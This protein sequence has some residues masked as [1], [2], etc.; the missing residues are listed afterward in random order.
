MRILQTC[1]PVVPQ[2]YSPSIT[3]S[4]LN[5]SFQQSFFSTAIS[6]NPNV[7]GEDDLKPNWSAFKESKE[8]ML[9]NITAAG[10]PEVMTIPTSDALLERCSC[11]HDNQKFNSEN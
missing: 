5:S 3:A 11:V 2:L 1:H 6:L 9:F 7:H 8:T 4:A 10:E